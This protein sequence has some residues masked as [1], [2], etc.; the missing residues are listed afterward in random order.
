MRS[1]FV[2]GGL[3][4]SISAMAVFPGTSSDTNTSD[5]NFVG[6]LN[7]ASGVLIGSD[8]VLTAKHVGAGDFTLPGFGTFGVVANSAVSDPNSDLTLFRINVGSLVLPHATIDVSQMNFGVSG[9]LNGAG[10]GYDQN[11]SGGVRRKAVG[12]YEFTDFIDEPSYHGGYSLI[13]PLRHNG[14]AALGGGDSGGG[15][16]RNGN[17]V[18]TSAFIGTYG[19]WTDFAFSNS[20]TNFFVSGA[21]SLSDNVQFL[22]NNNVAFV[23]EPASFA[24]LGLGAMALL[25]RKRK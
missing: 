22:R 13:A 16:F 7:G 19:T 9:A 25:R 2:L 11:V 17:L 24:V 14:Q 4:L 6:Q 23:P 8:M 21:I 3:C 15:W 1:I 20:N 10:D 5:F 18:G 12:N